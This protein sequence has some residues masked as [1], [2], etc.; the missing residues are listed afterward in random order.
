MP[1]AEEGIQP[2]F[3]P[4]RLRSLRAGFADDGGH[5]MLGYSIS[6]ISHI[7]EIYFIG[8]PGGA[9]APGR[10]RFLRDADPQE[11]KGVRENLP[12]CVS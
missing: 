12:R 11:A 7:S 10:I 3:R 5:R 9:L 8:V 6:E 1:A 4:P 2:S